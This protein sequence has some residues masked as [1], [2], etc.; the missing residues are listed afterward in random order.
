[1]N[2]T[3]QVPVDRLVTNLTQHLEKQPNDAHAHYVLAR[4]HSMA[5]ARGGETLP[6]WR[7]QTE[8]AWPG[9]APWQTVREKR[10]AEAAPD[11]DTR[12]HFHLSV[13]HYRRAAKLDADQALY[14][15]GLAWMLDSGTRW[16]RVLLTP[17][18]AEY[19]V[20]VSAADRGKL[21][22]LI[23]TLG[24]APEE[25]ERKAAF[26]KLVHELPRAFLVAV[27]M[28]D[29]PEEPKDVRAAA[30]QVLVRY[31]QELALISYR[32]AF[33][34]AVER[35]L[36]ADSLG[37]EG[38]DAISEE[39]GKAIL[40]LTKEHEK[41]DELRAEHE[42]VEKAL[43][44]LAERPRWITP[45][46]FPVHGDAPLA[47]L[48]DESR[49]VSFDL[50]GD[51]I[52]GRWPWLRPGAAFLV[53]APEGAPLPRSG[54]QLFGSVTWWTF[55]RDGYQPLAA[56][57]DDCDG[58]L[59]GRELEGVAVW[60][61]ADADAHATA[62]EVIPA[63]DFGITAIAVEASASHDGVPAHPRGIRL[64]DGSTRPTYDWTPERLPDDPAPR[65]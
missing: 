47:A 42:R 51:D 45:I 22:D 52:P 49:A 34:L 18:G 48:V 60:H 20:D 7:P 24:T 43:K 6:L 53:W 13:I 63:R 62:D 59:T 32:R 46:V 36:A 9:F 8:G 1:M 12:R 31:W 37:A 50:D 29:H 15:L 57:D 39:A 21:E 14:H 38:D 55:W 4:V 44:K 17:D 54:R 26:G 40:R 61:D 64:R 3:E 2:D 56:L 65:P 58:A 41:T 33:E 10:N 16:A 11:K 19:K 25:D 5:W 23:R 27:N 30:E 35:D 28:V